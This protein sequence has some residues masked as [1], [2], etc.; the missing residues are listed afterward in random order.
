M[1]QYRH[2]ATV[3]GELPA[4]K[5]FRLPD[6]HAFQLLLLKHRF[7]VALPVKLGARFC[8]LRTEYTHWMFLRQNR[9]R[10]VRARKTS[11]GP[12]TSEWAT[13]A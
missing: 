7:Q 4:M 8:R 5:F 12:I 1:R 6:S 9:Q 3:G 13:P 2:F 11:Q 10:T